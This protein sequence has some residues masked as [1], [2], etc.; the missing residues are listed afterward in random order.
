[1]SPLSLHMDKIYSCKN[2]FK[3][4]SSVPE[5]SLLLMLIKFF[6]NDREVGSK[7]SI[8]V[9]ADGTKLCKEINLAE[10]IAT[11]H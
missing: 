8:S 2:Y 1:M 6:I 7:S 3:S 9:F 11:L 5:G 4:E 10:D